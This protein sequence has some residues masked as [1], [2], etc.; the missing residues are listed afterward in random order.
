MVA[1]WQS[2]VYSE[3]L[4]LVLGPVSPDLFDF[5]ISEQSAF[6]S[7]TMPDIFNE[8]ATAAF[9]YIRLSSPLFAKHKTNL[10]NSCF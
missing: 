2:I 3:F 8:F 9:R 10:L 5:G 1:E 4:P 7:T 6:D